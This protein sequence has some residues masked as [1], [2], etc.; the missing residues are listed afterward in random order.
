[1]S[2]L[3]EYIQEQL[4]K[5][6][7]EKPEII[8]GKHIF[9]QLLDALEPQ[10]NFDRKANLLW[11]F[12]NIEKALAEA[13]KGNKNYSRFYFDQ[14]NHFAVKED[15]FIAEVHNFVLQP[16]VAFY[17]YNCSKEFASAINRLT[18]SINSIKKI[19]DQGYP[20]MQAASV[21]QY[22]NIGRVLYKQKKKDEAIQAFGQLIHY[23]ITGSGYLEF[24]ELSPKNVLDLWNDKDRAVMLQYVTD[25]ALFKYFE[26][27]TQDSAPLLLKWIFQKT[28]KEDAPAMEYFQIYNSMA[29]FIMNAVNNPAP[30]LLN[31]LESSFPALTGMPRTLQFVFLEKLEQ[32][33]SNFIGPDENLATAIRNYCTEQLNLGHMF[34]DS[35]QPDLVLPLRV[36]RE[37]VVSI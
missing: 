12:T 28:G 17:E 23:L 34:A 15:A 31:T 20:F 13:R 21:E 19:I 7:N 22:L 29:C 27:K 33:Y 8:K 35:Q 10:L 26:Y 6:R 18:D 30:E 24:A 14:I 1:M 37:G 9:L 32:L 2:T 5:A 11:L 36:S 4:S 25:A 16:A 3:L